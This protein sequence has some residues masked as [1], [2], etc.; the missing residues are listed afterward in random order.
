MW[1]RT[2]KR[3]KRPAL[4][5]T[6]EITRATR[7]VELDGVEVI[8]GSIIALVDGRLCASG[9]D[10]LTVLDDLLEQMEMEECGIV[11]LYYGADATIASAETADHIRERYPDVEVEVVEG[12]QAHY[13]YI[14]GAE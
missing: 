14:L 4:V 9:S 1:R 11:T 12:G 7:S 13:T 5:K 6:G 10:E 3:W 8:E 2:P